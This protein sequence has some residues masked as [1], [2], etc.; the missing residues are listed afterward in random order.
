M[1][2]SILVLMLLLIVAADTGLM[3]AEFGRSMVGGI[4]TTH[5]Y[6]HGQVQWP[7]EK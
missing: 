1:L 7:F 3:V 6:T 4:R 5:T 2:A